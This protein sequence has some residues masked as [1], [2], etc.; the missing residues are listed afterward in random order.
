MSEWNSMSATETQDFVAADSN[1]GRFSTLRKLPFF[2]GASD[3]VMSRLKSR[4]R[5][6][7]Y[8]A[9]RTI[10]EHGDRQN[11]VFFIV[12]GAVRIVVRT[13]L[14]YEA[15]LNDMGVG[16]FFGELAAI[17]GIQRSASV[18]TL[19][20]TRLC[21]FPGEAFMEAV[22]TSPDVTR[23]LLRML[24]GRLRTKDERLVEFGTLT[25]RE[26]LIAELLRLSRDR[27]SGERVLSP[28]PPQHV[29]AARIGTRRESVSRELGEMSRAGYLTVGRQAIVLHKPKA[30]RAEVDA[31]LTG[32]DVAG[33]GDARYHP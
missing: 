21:S 15:I 28:P 20:R 14:G 12:E 30:L 1:E 24:S 2:T 17:D 22:L 18:T 32:A 4:A 31:R 27:G 6:T 7:V 26:R 5:W 9:E 23:R 19:L 3:D 29:L 10:L 16:E 33:T 13:A 11:D 25:V 8:P